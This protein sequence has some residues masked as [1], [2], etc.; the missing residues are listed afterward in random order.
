MQKKSPDSSPA[1]SVRRKRATAAIIPF[2][3][4]KP[5]RPEG[6]T[7]DPVL[8]TLRDL[9]DPTRVLAQMARTVMERERFHGRRVVYEAALDEA[10]VWFGRRYGEGIRRV[11]FEAAV[12]AAGFIVRKNRKPQPVQ[13][14]DRDRAKELLRRQRAW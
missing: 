2:R 7:E 5:G 6:S 13:Q 1:R 14:P 10:M 3:K 12:N 8:R 11:R 4:K 9:N